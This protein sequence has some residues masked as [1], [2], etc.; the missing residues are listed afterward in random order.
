[1]SIGVQPAAA[2]DLGAVLE[3]ARAWPTHFV[4]EGLAAIESSFQ[5]AKAIVAT[6]CGH[7]E[8]FLIWDS[9]GPV[10]ELLW[11][12]VR[13]ERVRQGIGTTLVRAMRGSVGN[14]VP[15]I[16]KTATPDSHIPGSLFDARGFSD[17]IR[18]YEALGFFRKQVLNRH[19]GPAN[20]AQVMELP[21]ARPLE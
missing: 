10:P 19:W 17:T 6:E 18:F 1:M 5:K 4:D 2:A 3:I 11:I 7:V 16:V 9:T 14:K 15:I 20:H 21:P 12:A 13:P 8:G